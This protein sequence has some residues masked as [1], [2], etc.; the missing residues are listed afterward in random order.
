MTALSATLTHCRIESH[1]I[2]SA[3]LLGS[4]VIGTR[5]EDINRSNL[6]GLDLG[7]SILPILS[8]HASCGLYGST[9]L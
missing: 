4:L 1:E 2:C 9:P 7:V 5:V 6:V 8:A 3:C